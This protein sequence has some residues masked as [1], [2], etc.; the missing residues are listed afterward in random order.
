MK[1]DVIKFGGTSLKN[2][3]ARKK[4]IALI[5]QHAI[6]HSVVAVVSAM[7]RY[8]DA[9]A[10]DTLASLIHNFVTK[11]EKDRLL[12]IGEIISSIV[13]CDELI[14]SGLN[15][16][17]LSILKAG[18]MTDACYGRASVEYVRTDELYDALK[19]Y[20]VVVV[21]GFQGLSPEKEVTTLGRGGSDY[22]AVILA[23]ALHLKKATIYS[24]VCGIYSGDPKIIE[25][26]KLL[27]EI[28]YHQAK[29]IARYK[30]NVINEDAV[31]YAEKYHIDLILKST[32]EPEL[33]TIIKE[34]AQK[35]HCICYANGYIEIRFEKLL[36]LD[37]LNRASFRL[38]NDH[39]IFEK[40]ELEKLKTPYTL[41]DHYT[42]VHFVGFEN[43]LTNIL[44]DITNCPLIKAQNDK[45]TFFIPEKESVKI[46]NQWHDAIILEG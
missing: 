40:K 9:Y 39:Y 22:S 30:S 37:D 45:N 33:S 36:N 41:I 4:A 38:A 43:D 6:D 21:P 42:M 3:E 20:Q 23:R 12:S 1:I 17:S 34:Q 46:I 29:E 35:Q 11:K 27:D 31:A 32:F 13:L 16:T 10:T 8:D 14:A 44:K 24:D 7:G 26:V 5:Q 19:K 15:A 2:A 25:H 28:S 18:I